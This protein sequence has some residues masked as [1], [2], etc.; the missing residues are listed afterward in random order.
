MSIGY[1]CEVVLRESTVSGNLAVASGGGFHIRSS[2]SLLAID[3]QLT[4]NEAAEGADGYLDGAS[5]ISATL[6]CCE[7]DPEGW[8]GNGGRD[9]R[10]RLRLS[11]VAA[12][13]V[14]R[15]HPE[16]LLEPYGH[17][18]QEHGRQRLL[19][20]G[21]LV[22]VGDGDLHERPLIAFIQDSPQVERILGHIGEPVEAPDVLPARSP[23]QGELSF[24]AGVEAVDREAWPKID[25]TG[26][27]DGGWG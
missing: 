9:R 23:P 19:D 8:F 1:T 15:P 6:V 17:R 26:G 18:V 12:R 27:S 20:R 4:G 25:Q 14:L 2:S 5:D 10:R 11:A 22:E 7:V 3:C 16:P 21:V 24:D 13:S